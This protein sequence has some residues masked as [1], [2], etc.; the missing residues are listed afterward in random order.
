MSAGGGQKDSNTTQV[1]QCLVNVPSVLEIQSI[2][3]VKIKS[4]TKYL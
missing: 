4:I 1:D 3:A 2:K